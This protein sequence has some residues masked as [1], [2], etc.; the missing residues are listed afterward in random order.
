MAYF[1][2]SY[3]KVLINRGLLKKQVNYC[4]CMP[5]D[6]RVIGNYAVSNPTLRYRDKRSYVVFG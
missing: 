6:L 5:S 4:S 1:K 2:F 3:K